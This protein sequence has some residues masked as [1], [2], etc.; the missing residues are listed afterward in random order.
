M[1][2][3]GIFALIVALFSGAQA[4]W[5]WPFDSGPVDRKAKRISELIEPA[6]LLIDEATDLAAENKVD[7]AVAKYRKALAELNRIESENP[8][9]AKKPEFAT[10]RTKRAYV[11][12]AVDSLLLQQVQ[13]NA[14]AV[15]VSDTEELEKRLDRERWGKRVDKAKAEFDRRRSDEALAELEKACTGTTNV[16]LIAMSHDVMAGVHCQ[17]GAFQDACRALIRSR[18]LFSRAGEMKPE[19]QDLAPQLLRSVWLHTVSAHRA[20]IAA[21]HHVCEESPRIETMDLSTSNAVV[22]ADGVVRALGTM[23]NLLE[24]FAFSEARELNRVSSNLYLRASSLHARME[25]RQSAEKDEDNSEKAD[26]K[27]KKLTWRL[28]VADLAAA[29]AGF[30]ATAPEIDKIAACINAVEKTLG[31]EEKKEEEKQTSKPKPTE[32]S[33]PSQL[34]QPSQPLSK[35]EQAIAAISNGDWT[36]AERV[37]AEMLVEKPNGVV[38]LNLKAVMESRQGKYKEAEATLYRAISSHPRSHFAFYNMA[39]LMLQ[40]RKDDK[41]VAKRYYETGRVVGGP[42]DANLEEALK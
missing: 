14:K 35:R 4:S 15:A 9:R 3:F 29:L 1:R 21:G 19:D 20:V 8:D 41:S 18:Q 33:N 24:I 25:K 40:V 38:A 31:V 34:S 11:N 5:Y 22:A 28:D 12:A 6:S 17:K 42:V 36:T 23:S 2:K 13:E 16:A 27:R 26:K 32:S 10:L 30:E 39:N 7:E 37:I